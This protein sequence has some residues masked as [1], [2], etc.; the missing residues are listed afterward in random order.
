MT[1]K[2]LRCID[3]EA[4]SKFLQVGKFINME[5]VNNEDWLYCI[6]RLNIGI[7]TSTVGAEK[8]K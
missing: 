5:L 7:Q 3:F 6:G 1:A 8:K 4:T 2:T